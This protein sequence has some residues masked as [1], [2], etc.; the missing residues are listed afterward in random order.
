MDLTA[1]TAVRGDDSG[2]YKLSE[3]V[4][5]RSMN[6]SLNRGPKQPCWPHPNEIA[7]RR[8]LDSIDLNNLEWKP[9]Y[10]GMTN[11]LQPRLK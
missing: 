1:Q 4:T 9:V 5:S 7:A 2:K 11:P 8:Q 6:G 3:V 10:G